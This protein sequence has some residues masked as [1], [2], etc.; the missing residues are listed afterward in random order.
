MPAD[1][2]P[3]LP[4]PF[5]ALHEDV[6]PVVHQAW[7]DQMLAYGRLVAQE[8]AKLCDG[9]T[10]ALDNGGNPYRREALASQCAAAI[11][12]KYNLE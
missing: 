12:K 1:G 7:A 8:C 6:A 10:T 3:P 2:M 11:R 9:L 4:E 5:M